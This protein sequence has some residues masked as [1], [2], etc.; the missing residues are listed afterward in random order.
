MSAA[1]AWQRLAGLSGAA[2]VAFGAYGAHGFKPEKESSKQVFETGNK[3]HLIHSVLL[4]TAPLS[5]RPNV[6]GALCSFGILGFSG[7]CYAAA[8]TED[9]TYGKL[10]PVG[11]F[12]LISAW[13][14]LL[15]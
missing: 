9:R 8:L 11:G 13:L 3:Y 1:H 7:S 5:K 10:A 6:F 4:A 14:V 12:S 2:S 15:L